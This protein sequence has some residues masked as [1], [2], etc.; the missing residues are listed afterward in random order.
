MALPDTFGCHVAGAVSAYLERCRI[1]WQLLPFFVDSC[2]IIE[3]MEK[4]P[5]HRGR[6]AKREMRLLRL[7][8]GPHGPLARRCRLRDIKEVRR[9]GANRR[10]SVCAWSDSCANDQTIM[11]QQRCENYAR[12]A[13]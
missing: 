3:E 9:K 12:E 2:F 11:P 4:I 13:N 1:I 7:K 6:N 5:G 8:V 10:T